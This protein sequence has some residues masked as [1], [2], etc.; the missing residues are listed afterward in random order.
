MGTPKPESLKKYEKYKSTNFTY[1][2][3]NYPGQGINITKPLHEKGKKLLYEMLKYDPK[4][5]ATAAKILQSMYFADL[6]VLKQYIEQ[7]QAMNKLALKHGTMQKHSHPNNMLARSSMRTDMSKLVQSEVMKTQPKRTKS[8]FFS[9]QMPASKYKFETSNNVVVHPK[10]L[11]Q[12]STV[13]FRPRNLADASS[14]VIL[15]PRNLDANS[16]VLLR[17]RNLDATSNTLLRAKNLDKSS[18]LLLRPRNLSKRH[19]SE[20]QLTE[21]ES[22]RKIQS[23]FLERK[24][25]IKQKLNL[26]F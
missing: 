16:N 4:R 15:R 1:H 19:A 24:S 17:P 22:R 21:A 14:N 8:D 13:L 11:E 3:K 10:K 9:H 26:L 20:R 2:F 5:R 12:P 23:E 6:G 7:K 18:T 25:K